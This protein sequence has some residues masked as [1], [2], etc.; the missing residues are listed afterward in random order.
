MIGRGGKRPSWWALI[1]VLALAGGLR[2]WNLGSPALIGDE[3]YYRLWADHLALC[4]YDNPAGVALLVRAGSAL[5]PASEWGTRWL[6]ALL[7]VISAGLVWALGSRLFSPWARRAVFRDDKNESVVAALNAEGDSELAKQ[8][9]KRH[10][11]FSAR[12]TA[13]T[14]YGRDWNMGDLVTVEHRGEDIDQKIVG[15]YVSVSESGEENIQ[16]EVEDA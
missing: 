3:A 13:A 14:R 16:P 7:G 1:L 9:P 8:E 2:F 12:Q 15:V 4:Y 10:F 5:A 11:E 6:N